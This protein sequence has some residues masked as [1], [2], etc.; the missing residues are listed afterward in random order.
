MVPGMS[1]D[2]SVRRQHRRALVI[3]PCFGVL[4]GVI[5]GVAAWVVGLP[6]PLVIGLAVALVSTILQTTSFWFGWSVNR[7]IKPG[8]HR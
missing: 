5:I 4:A 8:R 6:A 2:E 1:A 7:R 3:G